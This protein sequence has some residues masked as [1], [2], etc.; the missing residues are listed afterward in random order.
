MTEFLAAFSDLVLWFL[1]QSAWDTVV[2]SLPFTFVI[3]SMVILAFRKLV[4]L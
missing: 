3:V 1:S 4:G 2:V